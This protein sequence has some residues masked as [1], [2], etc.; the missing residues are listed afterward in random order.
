MIDLHCHLL[1]GIDD[2]PEN[3]DEARVLAESAAADGI[4][5]I[6]AT[7]HLRDDHPGVNPEELRERCTAVA[8]ALRAADVDIEV[9]PAGEVDLVWALDAPDHALDLVSYGQRG[10]DVLVETPYGELNSNFEQMLFDRFASRD[11]RVLLAH[12]ERN[13][14][15]REDPRRLSELV[16]RGVLVQ[17]TASSLIDSGRRSRSRRMARAMIKE[18]IAH[19]IASD[20]HGPGVQ[21]A[22]LSAGVAEAARIDP[23]RAG[24]MV[25]DAPRAI[26]AGEPLPPPPSVSRPRRGL[27][28]RRS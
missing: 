24:W 5:V 11:V 12:P 26:L 6:A 7:P 14:T 28:G 27:F 9:V 15:L 1:P 17:V 21:R 13:P 16:R 2:G 8:E 4:E 25:D 3:L 10:S 18:G 19:V 23:G 22:S 20:S